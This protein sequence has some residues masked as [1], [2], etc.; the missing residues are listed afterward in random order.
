MI[1]LVFSAKR[2]HR[3]EKQAATDSGDYYLDAMEAGRLTENIC[4]WL[5]AYGRSDAEKLAVLAD[6][7]AGKFPDTTSKY[8]SY[9]KE[10]SLEEDANSWRLLDY[11]LSI[12]RKELL[13]ADED[14]MQSIL[15]RV[16][17]EMPLVTA[18]L[19]ISFWEKIQKEA[20]K[21]GWTYRMHATR[22]DDIICKYDERYNEVLMWSKCIL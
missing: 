18:K 19:F 4:L 14:E 12:L 9:I 3:R 2:F 22:M 8:V 5:D 1:L 15:D 7:G 16:S 10:S 13:D 17:R 11:L 21:N 20:G 6:Y